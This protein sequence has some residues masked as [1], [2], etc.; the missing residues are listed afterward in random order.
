MN[1]EL[2]VL[3]NINNNNKNLGRYLNPKHSQV[4]KTIKIK[5]EKRI[6]CPR[7]DLNPRPSG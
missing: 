5:N 6:E 1:K 4:I 7:R 3:Y 2:K